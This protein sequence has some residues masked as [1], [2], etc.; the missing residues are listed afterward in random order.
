MIPTTNPSTGGSS[1]S[2][3][4][5]ASNVPELV[6]MPEI[7]SVLGRKDPSLLGIWGVAANKTS[8]H[9]S[10]STKPEKRSSVFSPNQMGRVSGPKSAYGRNLKRLNRIDRPKIGSACSAEDG[11]PLVLYLQSEPWGW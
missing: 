11:N 9:Q 1:A 2:D 8:K 3:S 10:E 5:R 7:G 6:T 4:Q